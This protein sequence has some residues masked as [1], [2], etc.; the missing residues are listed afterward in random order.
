MRFVIALLAL[1]VMVVASAGFGRAIWNGGAGHNDAS[2]RIIHYGAD[3]EMSARRRE[4][5]R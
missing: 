2:V 4:Q 5:A 1:A 3:Y